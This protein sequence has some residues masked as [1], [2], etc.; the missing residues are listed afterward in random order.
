MQNGAL[1]CIAEE[2]FKY[3]PFGDYLFGPKLLLVIFGLFAGNYYV[4]YLYS[5][6]KGL[7]LFRIVLHIGICLSAAALANTL[8][9]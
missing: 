7:G 8:S 4:P 5:L 3:I 9:Q 6:I 2:E 1:Q